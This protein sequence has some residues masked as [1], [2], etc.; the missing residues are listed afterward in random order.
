MAA[1]G[2]RFATLSV[3]Q[4]SSRQTCG[5]ELDLDGVH[6]HPTFAAIHTHHEPCWTD[7]F[8]LLTLLN[9][10]P[11][12]GACLDELHHDHSSHERA[13]S[14]GPEPTN[15]HRNPSDLN[16]NRHSSLGC[17]LCTP[18]LACSHG[19]VWVW[20]SKVIDGQLG[21]PRP[22]SIQQSSPRWDRDVALSDIQ[23][24]QL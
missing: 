3:S 10:G 14:H 9:L 2:K 11:P 8:F 15:V 20:V 22:P 5:S 18:V 6:P 17:H 19:Q 1:Q 24:F 23:R 13:H 21:L 7:F 12:E 4:G 16:R